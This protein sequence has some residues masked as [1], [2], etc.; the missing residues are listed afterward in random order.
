M[1]PMLGTIM[2]VFCRQKRWYEN[3]DLGRR[4]YHQGPVI[5][6]RHEW[7][8]TTSGLCIPL[9]ALANPGWHRV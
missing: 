9:L 2:L 6:P 7:Q 3:K 1:V 8:I 4:G 5:R